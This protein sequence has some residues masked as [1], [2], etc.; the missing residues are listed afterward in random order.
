MQRSSLA[1]IIG[2]EI[3]QHED[4]IGMGHEDEIGQITRMFR[5]E[6]KKKRFLL[7]KIKLWENLFEMLKTVNPDVYEEL[8]NHAPPI[9]HVRV[10]KPNP[11]NKLIRPNTIHAFSTIGKKNDNNNISQSVT[12]TKILKR[13]ASTMVG[14]VKQLANG[15]EGWSNKKKAISDNNSGNKKEKSNFDD[16]NYAIFDGKEYLLRNKPENIDPSYT[17]GRSSKDIYVNSDGGISSSSKLI[18]NENENEKKN[19]VVKASKDNKTTSNSSNGFHRTDTVSK[20]NIPVY[21]NKYV[22]PV[23][24]KAL[25]ESLPG[26]SC[27]QCAEFYQ[28]LKDQG[29]DDVE[30]LNNCSRHKST[31]KPPDT[32]E[33]FWSLGSL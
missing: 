29:F 1:E 6:F 11:V 5:L 14:D 8:K 28:A 30:L 32:P 15:G 9:E 13:S 24:S 2:D 31:W 4:R 20:S 3:R 22:E 26:H 27:I 7:K 10:D 18:E 12:S 25:R 33:G 21:S 17:L 19:S 23:R 16:K